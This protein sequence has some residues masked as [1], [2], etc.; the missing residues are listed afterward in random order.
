MGR[1]EEANTARVP[2]PLEPLEVL[3][4]GDEV[5]HL[6]EV[7]A[8]CEE[9]ELVGELRAAL[10]DRA[11]PDLRGHESLLSPPGERAAEHAL[12]AAVHR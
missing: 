2:L 4:P 10:L 3:V 6:L 11:G 8:A 12:G 5:V 7:D 1:S 9:A